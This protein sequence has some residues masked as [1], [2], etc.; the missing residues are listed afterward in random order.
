MYV[1]TISS[2]WEGQGDR[3]RLIINLETSFFSTTQTIIYLGFEIDSRRIILR[4]SPQKLK[5]SC[6]ELSAINNPSLRQLYSV[7]TGQTASCWPGLSPAPLH[8]KD[9]E[10]LKSTALRQGRTWASPVRL[11]TAAQKDLRWW[12]H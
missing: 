9:L 12:I 2:S 1:W 7:I 3:L 6:R 4:V 8:L 10:R 11:D 5:H